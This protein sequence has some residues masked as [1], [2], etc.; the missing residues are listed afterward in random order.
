MFGVAIRRYCLFSGEKLPRDYDKA[1]RYLVWDLL[2]LLRIKMLSWIDFEIWKKKR[3][4]E[5]NHENKE[6]LLLLRDIPKNLFIYV[7]IKLIR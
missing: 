5:N 6:H 4:I 7:A 1:G 3:R 2:K